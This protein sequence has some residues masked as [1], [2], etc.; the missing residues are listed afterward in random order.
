MFYGDTVQD[1]RSLFYL[2]WQKYQQKTHAS[3]LEQ[4]LIDVIFCL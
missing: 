4:Q 3:P 2:S 1:T